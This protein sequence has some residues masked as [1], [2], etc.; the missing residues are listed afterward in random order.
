MAYGTMWAGKSV[1]GVILPF[2]MHSWL[3]LYGPRTALR[4]WAITL[5]VLTAPLLF[6]LKPRIPITVSTVSPRGT[7]SWNFLQATTFWMLQ[8]GNIIQSFGYFL[9]STYLAS[10]A[11]ALGLPEITG[12]ILI[13]IF[14][15]ASVPGALA[16]GILGDH[17]AVTS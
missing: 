1:A 14:N 8:L 7:L 15:F 13:A 11:H 12:T 2:I 5:F 17:L 9:P 16:I 10:Y 3:A 4:V 6:F